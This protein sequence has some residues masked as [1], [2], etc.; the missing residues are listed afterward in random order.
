MARMIEMI[1]M[2]A[3]LV[4]SECP[5][6]ELL[7]AWKASLSPATVPPLEVPCAPA[8]IRTKS[9]AAIVRELRRTSSPVDGGRSLMD[10]ARSGR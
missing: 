6:A 7:A 10:R 2:A 1:A 5:N 8:P 3:A 4:A 9:R